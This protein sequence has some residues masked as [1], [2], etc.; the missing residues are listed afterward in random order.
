MFGTY[1]HMK[2]KLCRKCHILKPLVTFEQNRRFCKEC[3][4]KDRLCE[5]CQTLKPFTDFEQNRRVC[6]KCKR[7]EALKF[8]Y[9]NKNSRTPEQI[10]HRTEHQ[11]AYAQKP[12]IIIKKN[13]RAR[14]HYWQN[15]DEICKKNRGKHKLNPKPYK[16]REPYKEK[17]HALFQ[18]AVKIGRVK[19]QPCIICDKFPAEGHHHDYWKPLKVI[20]LCRKHHSA[21][22][23]ESFCLYPRLL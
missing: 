1:R 5:K 12:E 18:Y 14:N 23:R 13:E 9:R 16:P 7:K 6:K 8:Y 2:S 10:K 17:C 3:R 19:K 20:W 4:T 21:L 15:R 22:H 11:K